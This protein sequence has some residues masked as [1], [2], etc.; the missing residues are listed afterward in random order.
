M[1]MSKLECDAISKG[2]LGNALTFLSKNVIAT[3][4]SSESGVPTSASRSFDFTNQ[5][6]TKQGGS[7]YAASVPNN[8]NLINGLL[9]VS[10]L[11]WGENT[12]FYIVLEPDSGP[13]I[14]MTAT[15]DGC[16]VGYLRAGDGAVRVSHHNVQSFNSDSE[17]K[18]TLSFATSSLHPNQYRY[19]ET[20]SEG[21]VY[22]KKQGMGFVFGVRQ[23]RK[24]TMYAQTVASTV[25]ISLRD[26]K[27]I[28]NQMTIAKAWKF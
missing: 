28:S 12:G 22:F 21:E 13:D 1:W 23:K 7:Y 24:W 15:M 16:S 20:G 14:M 17:Q 6:R 10:Y 5:G 4:T 18:D 19:N 11:P 3:G 2:L 25:K 26:G 27:L 9:T 8:V